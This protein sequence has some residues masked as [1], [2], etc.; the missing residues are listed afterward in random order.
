[1]SRREKIER[2]VEMEPDDVFLNFSLAMEL[3]KEGL[4]DEA[5]ARFDRV[6]E[7]DSADIAAYVQK[8]S[9]L[10]DAGRSV[11]A[12]ATLSL[13]LTVAEK[14]GDAHMADQMRQLLKAIG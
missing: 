11:D 5:I 9:V 8:G 10:I 3:V 6:L 2:L 12:R 4:I 1:M 7:L 14:A 13:G